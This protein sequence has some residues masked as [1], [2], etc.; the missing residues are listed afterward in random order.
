MTQQEPTNFPQDGSIAQPE[1]A[2]EALS[3]V[4]ARQTLVGIS[5]QEQLDKW[6]D[7]VIPKARRPALR[8]TSYVGI[9]FISFLV[10]LYFTFPYGILKE[11]LTAKISESL[12]ASGLSMRVSLGK[13]EPYWLTGVSISNLTIS[14]AATPDTKLTLSEV[15]TRLNILPLFIG[16]ISVSSEILQGKTGSIRAH[17]SI[18]VLDALKGAPPKDLKVHFKAFALDAFFQQGLAF[19]KNSK[20]TAMLLLQPILAKSSAGGQL[21]GYVSF[22]NTDSSQSQGGVSDVKLSILKGFLH[23]DDNT[24]QIPRQ[25]FNT[26]KIDLHMEK[27]QITIAPG[28]QFAAED[29]D[30]TLGGRVNLA[31]PVGQ[32]EAN[33]NLTLKMSGQIEKNL[34]LI[35]PNILRCQPLKDGL[36]QAKLEGPV[37]NLACRPN[38]EAP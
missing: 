33:L 16:R 3:V 15:K 31:S 8:Y 23:I 22:V 38:T 18:P 1:S 36:L 5:P 19:A 37:S 32:P 35:V 2:A 20:D 26:A 10:F 7:D 34:G 6:S 25:N 9:G 21:S 13:M 27:N 14:Q 11:L 30:I 24:L 29:L 17:V 12:A 28:T 4:S